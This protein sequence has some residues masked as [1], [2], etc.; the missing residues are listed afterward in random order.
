M[1]GIL[2]HFDALS[3]ALVAAGFPDTS[4]WWRRELRR[5]L[6]S[7]K[8]RW[9]IRAGR[10]AGKS[11]TLCRLAAAWALFGDWSVPPGDVAVVAFVSVSRDESAASARSAS[12]W[13]G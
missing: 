9:I 4:A 3:R 6:K 11:T 2:G 5:F 10:R 1:R 7:G 12:S 13:R 8:R